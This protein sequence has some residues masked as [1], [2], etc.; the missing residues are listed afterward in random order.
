[1]SMTMSPEATNPYTLVTLFTMGAIVCFTSWGVADTPTSGCAV[2]LPLRYPNFTPNNVLQYMPGLDGLQEESI[3]EILGKPEVTAVVDSLGQRNQLRTAPQYLV[4]PVSWRSVDTQYFSSRPCVTDF[5][6]AFKCAK[7]PKELGIPVPYR[8][9]ELLLEK[10]Q[11]GIAG[12]GTDLWALGCTLFEIRTGRKLFSLFDDDE[13]AYLDAMVEIL[14]VM[15]EP[16]W[17][18]TWEGRRKVYEDEP[19]EDG[20]AVYVRQ[21]GEEQCEEAAKSFHHPSVA[22]GARSIKEK[23][24]A[25]VWYM[26]DDE[27]KDRHREMSEVELALFADLLGRLL[28]WKPEER[29]SAEE[30]PSHEWFQ[31]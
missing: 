21:D 4:Y 5:G 22:Q 30:L 2:T 1:M 19:G 18:T 3:F 10:N 29:E 31:M 13:D 9:P 28:R 11:P 23:L 20:R 14:G 25:G 24:A 15:S 16:W 12:L 6:E 26:S 17:S 7:P 27:P 8:S